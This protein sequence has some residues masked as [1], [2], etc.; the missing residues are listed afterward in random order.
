MILR[1]TSFRLRR[2]MIVLG[3]AHPQK[4]LGSRTCAYQSQSINLSIYQS[5]NQSILAR[6]VTVMQNGL[7]YS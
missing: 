5:I 4:E 2:T 6:L 3:K 1:A 7:G